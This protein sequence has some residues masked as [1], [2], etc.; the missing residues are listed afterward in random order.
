MKN[1]IKLLSVIII[2]TALGSCEHKDTPVLESK[3]FELSDTMMHMIEMDSV[4]TFNIGD[5]ISLSGQISFNENNVIKVFP[6]NSGQVTTCRVSLG[7]KVVKGQ[8]LATV[9]SAD[10]AGN[11]SDLASANADLSIATRQKDNAEALYKNGISS[12]KE[13]NEA[14][15]NYE[16]AL[17]ARNKVQS[18]INING[19][20][21]TQ[22]GGEYL[23]TAPIDGYIV[24]K[25]VNAG[26]Y[27]RPDMGD[28]LFTISD[29][30]T[31]WV[32]ANIYEVDIPRVKL[33][34]PVKVI[35]LS[36]PDRNFEGKIDN[37]SEVLDVQ[38]KA[39]KA[40]ISIDNKEMLL[41]PDMFA[42]IIATNKEGTNALCIPT[43]ALISQ[44]GKNYVVIYKNRADIIVAEV[45]ILKTVGD[46]T[47][48]TSGLEQG[49]LVITKNQLLIF[50]KLTNFETQ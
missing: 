5:E 27:I 48:I 26:A 11:Y 14:K 46:K 22:E 34:Y 8:V 30:K 40:R 50:N 1:I 6:R 17:A 37:I 45:P 49:Q 4:R 24:E 41:K 38:S 16:K 20:A 44:D 9:K 7:D 2:Y 28:Y 23:L 25:K 33:G 3:K 42:K 43:S 19:G 10:I 31:V 21:K 39:L 15:Q 18:V 13:Y 32:Y 29:L 36:Y 35:T 47:Y 12:E